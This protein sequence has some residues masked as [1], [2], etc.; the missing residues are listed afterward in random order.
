MSA[1][2]V[3]AVCMIPRDIRIHQNHRGAP[4]GFGEESPFAQHGMQ[5]HQCLNG[6]LSECNRLLG[7]L[8]VCDVPAETA[9]A[10]SWA[11]LWL[12]IFEKAPMTRGD[13]STNENLCRFT[14]GFE[15]L[16]KRPQAA[17]ASGLEPG[18]R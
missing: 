10:D 11:R 7:D 15:P 18:L 12:A 16:A 1:V 14:A 5:E 4:R 13:V 17:G 8:F 2:M 6:A 3:K 9:K